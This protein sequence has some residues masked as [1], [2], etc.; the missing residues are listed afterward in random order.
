MEERTQGRVQSLRSNDE[1]LRRA[2]F[3]PL[4]SGCREADAA[5]GQTMGTGLP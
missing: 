4:L 2:E 1:Q 5:I 3:L